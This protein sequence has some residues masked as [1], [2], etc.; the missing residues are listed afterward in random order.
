M[1]PRGHTIN[2]LN[3]STPKFEVRK[4]VF[5]TFVLYDVVKNH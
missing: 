1:P 5:F 2:E 3:T 4:G